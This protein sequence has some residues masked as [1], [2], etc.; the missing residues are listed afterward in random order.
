MTEQDANQH[1]RWELAE[2]Q[3]AGH[4]PRVHLLDTFKKLLDASFQYFAEERLSQEERE[5]KSL[6]HELVR[7][8]ATDPQHRC[9]S[10]QAH[11]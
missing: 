5:R 1:L 8:A 4:L 7:V 10:F 11:H 6:K 9:G 3:I 2:D